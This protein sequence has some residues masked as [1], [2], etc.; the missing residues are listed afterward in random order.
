MGWSQLLM[1]SEQ[2]YEDKS[3]NNLEHKV[4]KRKEI[5]LTHVRIGKGHLQDCGTQLD[6]LTAYLHRNSPSATEDPRTQINITLM[7]NAL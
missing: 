6:V 1:A 2:G 7:K 5:Q 4:D 3:L